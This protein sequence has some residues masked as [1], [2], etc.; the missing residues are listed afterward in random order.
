MRESESIKDKMQQVKRIT[1]DSN[2]LLRTL[3]TAAAFA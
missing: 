1:T 2:A 3:L